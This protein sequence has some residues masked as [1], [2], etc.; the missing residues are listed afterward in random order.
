MERSLLD[1]GRELFKKS[2]QDHPMTSESLVNL[3]DDNLQNRMDL[4]TFKKL[5]SQN[6]RIN[7]FSNETLWEMFDK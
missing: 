4:D 7:G 6:E 3:T 2:N 5:V 1:R